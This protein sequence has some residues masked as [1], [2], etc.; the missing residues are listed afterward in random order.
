MSSQMQLT[1]FDMF[2]ASAFPRPSA[3]SDAI[4]ALASNSGTET[5]GAI[6]ARIEVV[7]FIL[8]LVGYVVSEPLHTRR[9]LEPSF[10]GGDFLLPIIG[11]LLASWCNHA[12]S[13]SSALDEQGKAIR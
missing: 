5:R 13:A 12:G 3:I 9:I 6:F 11:R 7:E 10:G 1:L 2:D 4:E 8:D